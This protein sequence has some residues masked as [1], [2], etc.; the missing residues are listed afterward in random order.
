LTVTEA[1]LLGAVQGLT[2]FL[3][4]S[5][6]AH[7]IFVQHY[8]HGFDSSQAPLFD[9]TLHVG[10]L[11]SLLVYYRREIFDMAASLL[12]PALGAQGAQAAPD[13]LDR[14]YV[15]LIVL[16]TIA[17]A[18]IAF[19]LRGFAESE[20]RDPRMIRIVGLELVITGLLLVT[21]ER[22][23][24]RRLGRSRV[25]VADAVIVGVGQGLG[26][27]FGGISRSGATIAAA[28]YRGLDPRAA[29]RFSF[30]LSIPAILGAVVVEGHSH[31]GELA[32]LDAVAFGTGALT[33]FLV[34]MAAIRV[35]VEFVQRGR[36]IYFALYCWA[37]GIAVMIFA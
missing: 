8:L 12:A 5:S 18:L 1:V 28:L 11:L 23:A 32:R 10:T 20:F 3:P 17:T 4:V 13:A 14:R 21:A 16:A 6:S 27:G 9:V 22:L 24:R 36:L 25:D 19:P 35:V 15:F 7:L 2:E 37:V 33:A 30:L 31:L 26:A 29:V 34:G